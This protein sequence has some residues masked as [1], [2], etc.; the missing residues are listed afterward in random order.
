M[1]RII[2]MILNIEESKNKLDIYSNKFITSY[3][4]LIHFIIYLLYKLFMNPTKYSLLL[5]FNYL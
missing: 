5:L 4:Y 1:K 3:H 2:I